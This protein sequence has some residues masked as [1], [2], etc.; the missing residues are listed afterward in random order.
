MIKVSIIHTDQVSIIHSDQ[1]FNHT[2]K[3][4]FQLYLQIKF[5]ILTL[6]ILKLVQILINLIKLIYLLKNSNKDKFS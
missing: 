2:F 6:Y 1:V 5:S 4:S 3:S